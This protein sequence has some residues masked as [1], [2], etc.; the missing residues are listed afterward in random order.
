MNQELI[1]DEQEVK[2]LQE[3]D[4]QQNNWNVVPLSLDLE[5]LANLEREQIEIPIQSKSVRFGTSL[6]LASLVFGST[7]SIAIASL[8]TAFSGVIDRVM[9]KIYSHTLAIPLEEDVNTFKNQAKLITKRS[10]YFGS[11]AIATIFTIINPLLGM[12][13]RGW[14]LVGVALGAPFAGLGALSSIIGMIFFG[15]GTVH[16]LFW[17]LV[18][19][20]ID[21]F[22]I[23]STNLFNSVLGTTTSSVSLNTLIGQFFDSISK[24]IL[25]IFGFL[26]GIGIVINLI[27]LILWGLCW[28]QVGKKLWSIKR[29]INYLDIDDLT[30]Y[31]YQIIMTYK[32]HGPD[33]SQLLLIKYPSAIEARLPE[34]PMSPSLLNTQLPE[35][36]TQNFSQLKDREK[37]AQTFS[38][39]KTALN[40]AIQ[41]N[42]K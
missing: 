20:S 7:S 16:S 4:G 31:W 35:L 10:M 9:V 23:G 41:A 19:G 13:L 22:I 8:Y 28:Y 38:K 26:P 33:Q 24:S 17:S 42:K 18:A 1:E 40:D 25:A 34:T 11:Q 29:S 12:I 39:L 2:L 3:L 32:I 5:Q 36:L 14:G 21:I 30:R 6:V 15:S 27:C 37:Y